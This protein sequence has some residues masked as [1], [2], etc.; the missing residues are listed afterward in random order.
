MQTAAKII[1]Q[2]ED[3]ISK[4]RAE[5]ETKFTEITNMISKTQK[6]KLQLA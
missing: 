4:I 5:N 1:A 3:E 6:F 2:H